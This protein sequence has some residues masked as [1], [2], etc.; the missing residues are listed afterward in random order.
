M[1]SISRCGKW[2]LMQVAD[3]RACRRSCMSVSFDVASHFRLLLRG[4]SWFLIIFAFFSG[5]ALFFFFFC[6]WCWLF[7]ILR[8][9][10]MWAASFDDS[11]R[12]DVAPIGGKWFSIA[13]YREYFPDIFLRFLQRWLFP[14]PAKRGE[15]V[16][17]L[18]IF[19]IDDW[20]RSAVLI[21]SSDTTFLLLLSIS[22]SFLSL[23]SFADLVCSRFDDADAFDADFLSCW[24]LRRFRFHFHFSDYAWLYF[25][26]PFII[27][28]PLFLITSLSMMPAIDYFW[29]HFSSFAFIFDFS[30]CGGADYAFVALPAASCRFFDFDLMC[31]R[32]D[33]HWFSDCWY[34]DADHDFSRWCVCRGR[35]GD[36]SSFHFRLRFSSWFPLPAEL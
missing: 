16:V 30:R 23:I 24:F 3:F 31:F 7:L 14:R 11:L 27:F 32:F 5:I 18:D 28:L 29:F 13:E 22:W 33:F 19:L 6:I 9:D 25:S 8:R 17:F 4:F 15:V 35:R 12:P 10:V 20:C 34:A 36:F 21:S 2:F 26:S 1:F